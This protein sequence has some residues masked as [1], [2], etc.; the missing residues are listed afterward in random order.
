M[1]NGDAMNLETIAIHA[2]R[3]IDPATKAVSMPLHTS[4]TFERASDGG[5]PAG[6]EYIR[7]ANPNRDAF[8]TCVAALEGGGEA[9]AFASGMAAITAVI[10]AS[11]GTGPARIIVP[12]D[13]YFGVRAVI[14]QTDLGKRFEFTATDMT[15]LDGLRAV[16]ASG[17]TSIVWV[18]TPSNPL[19][20]VIDMA[21]VSEIAH[22]AGA[23]VV[24]DNTWG[25][26]VLQRP[27]DFGADAVVH[28]ATKYIG[29]HSDLMLGAVVLREGSGLV[30]QL[31]SIQRN[32]GSVPSPFD[33]WMA[34]RGVQTL[35]V[36]MAAHC[37]NA[38][39]VATALS[40]HP[41]VEK[42]LY[43]GLPQDPGHA[44]ASRQMRGFGGMLSF[45][46]PGGAESAFRVTAA[47]RLVTRATSLG[48]THTLIEHR[49][50]VEGPGT[51]APP[52]LLRLSVGLEHSDD[53]VADLSGAIEA[54][55]SA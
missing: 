10:E 53:I 47:L 38:M 25:T 29:G 37:A 52:G 32:K 8:E 22:A 4:T 17:Q 15:D 5:F 46:V 36:R 16:L 9:V 55:R 23:I 7:D 50:S 44:V 35:P 21:A 31:R 42:V 30:S 14:D 39:A 11:G 24:V 54:A 13:M 40:A 12:S 49:A 33:C 45:I 19:I 43:P 28:S 34:L 26:P 1:Q 18:E 2:G 48:G 20:S 3:G 27:F 41:G 6:F 51:T